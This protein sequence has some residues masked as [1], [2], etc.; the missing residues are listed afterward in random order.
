MKRLVLVA[1][2]VILALVAAAPMASGQSSPKSQKLG[3]L[4]ASWWNWALATSPSPLEGSY[5]G[6]VQCDGAYV[7]GV[8]FLAG[9]ANNSAAS[10]ERTCTVPADTPILFPV[11]NVVCSAAFG[12]AGQD[13]PD[14][15]P[16]DRA[17]AE[18]ITGEVVDPPSSFYARVD[19][20]D[21]NQLRVASGHFA[22]KIASEANPYGLHAGT[23][24]AASDGLWV[25][26]NEGLEPGEHTV[27]FG[28]TFEDTPFGDF[29][30]TKVTYHLIAQ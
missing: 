24:S 22:W 4:T 29:E 13:P 3:N 21:V 26:L 15:K 20:E 14:P 18:P 17:C 7:K 23:Y 28:G 10:V 1:A 2:C 6:G 25:Y 19:G 12:A 16:Y 27:E 5:D 9:A 11:V 8:F 30:G